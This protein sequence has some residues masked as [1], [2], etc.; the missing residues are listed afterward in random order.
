MN[1]RNLLMVL[2]SLGALVAASNGQSASLYV[3][4]PRRTSAEPS[5]LSSSLL[6][7]VVRPKPKAPKVHDIVTVVIKEQSSYSSDAGRKADKKVE[8]D[9][10]I[11]AWVR[12]HNNNSLVPVAF[13]GGKPKIKGELSAGTDAK[14]KASRKDVVTF[15]VAARIIDVKPNGTCVLEARKTMQIDEEKRCMTL[16]GV[17]RKE[18]IDGANNTILSDRI[19][20]LELVAKYSGGVKDS[21]RKGWLTRLVEILSPF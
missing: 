8:V 5:R 12:F 10:S 20:G 9:A 17:C 19:F 16:T 18:D 1:G 7:A 11:D 14:G 21:T 15:R 2:L 4:G 6:T 13:E 3:A